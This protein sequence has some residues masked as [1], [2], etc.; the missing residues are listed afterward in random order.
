MLVLRI[1]LRSRD[2]NFTGVDPEN[3][4][5]DFAYGL[6][7]DLSYKN[8]DLIMYFQGVN[9]V[10]VINSVKYT[11]D[12]WSVSDTRSNKGARLLKAWDPVTNPDSNIPALSYSDTNNESRFS[13]YFVENGSYLKLRNIQLGY[14]IPQQVL[15][16]N[17]SRK[18][19]HLC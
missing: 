8:F 13:S 10:D 7:I 6:N 4:G 5:P 11:T 3:P 9:N 19:P 2:K 14:N 12:F 17:K 18:I 1:Y 16:K 15:H